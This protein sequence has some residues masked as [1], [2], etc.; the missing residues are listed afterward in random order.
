MATL[1]DCNSYKAGR[2]GQWYLKVSYYMKCTHG[3]ET[4][5]VTAR[6]TSRGAPGQVTTARGQSVRTTEVLLLSGRETTA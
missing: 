4:N 1:D 3:D 5:Q 2:T 6:I